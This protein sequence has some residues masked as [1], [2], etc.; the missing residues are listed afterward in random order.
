MLPKIS[1]AISKFLAPLVSPQ[2]SNGPKKDGEQKK[3]DPKKE[4]DDQ[5]ESAIPSEHT[6][7]A[8]SSPHLTVHSGGKGGAP[9]PRPGASV[10][11]LFLN[12]FKEVSGTKKSGHSRIARMSYLEQEKQKKKKSRFRKGTIVDDEA[13]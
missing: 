9:P 3:K 2:T 6:E 10:A 13:N 1:N 11:Q 5:P 4:G 8:P 7:P 12:L